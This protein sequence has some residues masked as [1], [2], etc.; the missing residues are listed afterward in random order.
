LI[1]SCKNDDDQTSPN[2]V[3]NEPYL[4][5]IFVF[6]VNKLTQSDSIGCGWLVCEQDSNFSNVV[7]YKARTAPNNFTFIAG[8]GYKGIFKIYP[9]SLFSCTDDRADP[10]YQLSVSYV[11]ILS[12]E[13]F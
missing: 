12:F 1:L 6:S 11:D 7:C 9:D 10:P 5:E 13:L 2:P 3:N 8:I 4:K